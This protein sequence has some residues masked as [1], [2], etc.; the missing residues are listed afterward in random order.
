MAS[1]VEGTYEIINALG[2]HARAAAQ[3]VKVANRFKSEVTIEAQGQQANA[4]SIM[5]VLMLAAAQGTQ[6]KLT[7]KGDDAEACLQELAKLIGD[8]F[9]EA[10]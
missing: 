8:R 1:V 9:G 4:K 2:L 5:G 6:V 10:Q 7:C 3:M